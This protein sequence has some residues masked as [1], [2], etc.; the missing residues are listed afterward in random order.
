[1]RLC[2]EHI[3]VYVSIYKYICIYIYMYICVYTCVCVNHGHLSLDLCAPMKAHGKHVCVCAFVPVHVDGPSDC[4]K[5]GKLMGAFV[6]G[7]PLW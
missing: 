4:T 7:A 1:M 6:K 3:Q 2:F 5:W